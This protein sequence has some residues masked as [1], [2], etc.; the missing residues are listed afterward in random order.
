M[1][2]LV[3]RFKP[4]CNFDKYVVMFQLKARDIS[5]TDKSEPF[6]SSLMFISV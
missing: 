2:I 4:Y 6:I 5:C 1:Q 3:D